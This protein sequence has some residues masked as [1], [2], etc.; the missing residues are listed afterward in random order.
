MK[1]EVDLVVP[2][3]K[4]RKDPIIN[5]L[6]SKLLNMVV[7]KVIGTRINDIGCNVK[8][9]SREVL[10]SLDLYGNMYRYFPAL[11]A[12]KG[13][14]IK[15]VECDQAEKVR[16]TKFYNIR[17]YLDRAIEILNLFFSTNYSKKPLRVFNFVGSS[18]MVFGALVLMYV[19]IQKVIFEIPI[20][21][22]PLLMVA[23]VSL[24]GG[25]QIASFGLLGEI[26]SFVHG[27]S[28]KEYTIEKI[29]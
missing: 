4:K 19:G 15:E 17:L 21:T 13:F 11:A 6:H 10:E 29:I 3:R 16:K 8:L 7:K 14:K 5:R 9:F 26:I 22:R 24:V 2:F 20:G 27:R 12:Q 25:T 28:R 18:F 1:D 23:M